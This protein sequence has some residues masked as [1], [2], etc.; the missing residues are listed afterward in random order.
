MTRIKQTKRTI[1]DNKRIKKPIKK[2]HNE[3]PKYPRNS[4]PEVK[5]NG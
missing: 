1:R 2:K 5:N 4:F 3:Y